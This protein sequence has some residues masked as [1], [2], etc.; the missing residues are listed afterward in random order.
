MSTRV[1]P[2]A[3]AAAH[4]HVSDRQRFWAVALCACCPFLAVYATQ[5]LLPSLVDLFNTSAKEVGLTITATTLAVAIA[6]PIS[7]VI[8]DAIG[9]KSVIVTC[10]LGLAIPVALAATA[11][12][13]QQLIMWR[14]IQGLF[15]PGIF[16]VTLAYVGEEWAGKNV[17][18]GMSAY[19][20][21]GVVGS[22]SG[23][24]ISGLVADYQG[25]RTAFAVLACV[26][27]LG[28]LCVWRFLPKSRNFVRERDI[29]IGLRNMG[30]HLKNP[31]MIAIFACAF[32]N[33]F[34]FVS[35]F[36]Y[37]TF[38]LVKPPFLLSEAELGF[39]FLLNLFGA[40]ANPIAGRWMGRVGYRTGL[41]AALATSTVGIL[42]TLVPDLIIALIGVALIS[43]GVFVAQTAATGQM[44]L[45]AGKAKSSAAGVY[46]CCYYAG[47]SVGAF[48]PGFAYAAGG[49]PACIALILA[50]KLVSA[51]V[52]I[53][54]FNPVPS[55]E[56]KG[57]PHPAY[58]HHQAPYGR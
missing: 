45:V 20:S 49:W 1:E 44:G 43:T 26:I 8:A 38:H 39:M 32:N 24:V 22:V 41:I 14:F 29:T 2:G 37:I 52:G 54:F 6:A 16:S 31:S 21:G 30:R 19:V 13:L 36:T 35:T 5:P 10:I 47:G 34:V 28:G 12:S 51:L 3:S 9:R 58:H 42:L 27:A 11:T 4:T 50:V 48:L 46:V 40:L 55:E 53:L 15:I 23:R 25:W 18:L 57:A 33:L 17:G 56:A 7:G